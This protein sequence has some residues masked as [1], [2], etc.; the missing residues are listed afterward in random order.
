MNEIASISGEVHIEVVVV[1]TISF[2]F[3]E[4]GRNYKD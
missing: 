3:A 4:Y 1:L 2:E